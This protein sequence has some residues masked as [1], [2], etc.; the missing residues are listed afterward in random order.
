M[1]IE[2]FVHAKGREHG[3]FSSQQLKQLASRGKIGTNTP[4]KQGAGGKWVHARRV[5]DL[6]ATI[7]R[8]PSPAPEPQPAIA[9]VE[10][11]VEVQVVQEP[12]TAEIVADQEESPRDKLRRL[13]REE[14]SGD[15]IR[16]YRARV[17][18][19]VAF[20]RIA[21]AIRTDIRARRKEKVDATD[22][23]SKLYQ[24]AVIE[25]FFEHVEWG[26]I[27]DERIL[28]PTTRPFIKRL[29]APYDTIGYANL[30]LL[31]K[32]DVKWLV[33]AFG[34]PETHSTA[35]DANLELWQEA[36]EAF[37]AAAVRDEQKFWRSRGFDPPSS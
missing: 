19:P 1:A 23:L 11:P 35:R 22:L 24:W 2:W 36:V 16:A 15:V 30:A 18:L 28:H 37:R 5:R 34:E 10:E 29:K 6:F 9:P 4:V 14:C 7:P 20:R 3:P 13:K 26:K 31:K 8:P 33:E 32:T 25:N 27:V 17:P 21:I 12:A